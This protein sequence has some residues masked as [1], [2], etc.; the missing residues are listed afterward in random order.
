VINKSGFV[1]FL[2]AGVNPNSLSLIGV[3]GSPTWTALVDANAHRRRGGGVDT[4]RVILRA[5]SLAYPR[6]GRE[7]GVR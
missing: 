2:D 5:P 7:R 1:I 4:V 6:A 3:G